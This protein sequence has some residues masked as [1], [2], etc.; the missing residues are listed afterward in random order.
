[1][2]NT[3]S[4]KL[5]KLIGALT[6][7]AWRTGSDSAD[8]DSR[9]KVEAGEGVGS[10]ARRTGATIKAAKELGIEIPAELVGGATAVIE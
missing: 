8:I 6:R 1:M 3:K 10:D 2:S 9:R 7:T 4:P 5:T